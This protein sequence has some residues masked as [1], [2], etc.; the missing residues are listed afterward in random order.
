MI[1]EC[2]YCG[3]QFKKP[4]AR[5]KYCS[6]DCANIAKRKHDW[7]AQ[8]TCIVCGKKFRMGQGEYWTRKTCGDTCFKQHQFQTKSKF[9]TEFQRKRQRP[10]PKSG[11]VGVSKLTGKSR[12]NLKKP[13]VANIT[14]DQKMRLSKYFSTK[15]EAIE[16]RKA[17]EIQFKYGKGKR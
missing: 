7:Q 17:W 3:D 12:G 5:A 9:Q 13:W 6:K 16:Q 2:K 4:R 8:L 10:P 14:D 1:I 11:F 15:E